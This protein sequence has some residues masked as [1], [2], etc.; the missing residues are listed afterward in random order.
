MPVCLQIRQAELITRST[1][2]AD[3]R[4]RASGEQHRRSFHCAKGGKDARLL[5]GSASVVCCWP[6]G[7]HPSSAISTHHT[8]AV[9]CHDCC[10]GCHGCHGTLF[11]MS[12]HGPILHQPPTN[13]LVRVDFTTYL[14]RY[15]SCSSPA[16]APCL[17][18]LLLACH[19][20]PW[21]PPAAQTSR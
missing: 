7:L 17:T 3:L 13:R 20:S 21:P 15:P 11:A 5:F 14:P 18:I 9:P 12:S 16:P 4:E 1:G 10:H 19:S 6:Q 8:C 2:V